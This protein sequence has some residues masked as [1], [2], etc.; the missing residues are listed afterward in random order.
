MNSGDTGPTDSSLSV[1]MPCYNEATTVAE[2]VAAVLAQPVVGEL[3]IVDDGSTDGTR[4]VLKEFDDPRVRVIEQPRNMGKG[5]ALRSGFAAATCP[6]VIVQDADLEYDPGEFTRL[7]APLV[8]G[9]A[10]V[11]YGSRFAGAGAHRVLMFWHS[12][13]NKFLTMASNMFTDLNLTDMETCYKAFR[14][15]VIQSIEIEED[16]FGFEPEVTAKIAAAGW[17]VFEIG[18][19]YN[20]RTYADGKKI[21]WRDGVRAVWCIIRYSPVGQRLTRRVER[22]PVPYEFADRE[23][24]S[25]LSVLEGATDYTDWLIE[26]FGPHLTGEIVE[27]GAG[28]GTITAH[29][30]NY[31]AVTAIEPSERAIESLQRRFAADSRVRVVHGDVSALPSA[32]C[33][34]VVL[35]NVLEHVPDDAAVLS[36]IHDA[37]RPDGRI[38]VFAPAF[39]ALYSEFD[40]QIGHYRRYQLNHLRSNLRSAGFDVVEARYVNSIGA[41]AWLIWAR[42]LGRTPTAAGPVTVYN[43]LFLP[44]LRR[45]ERSLR[46]PFGQSILVVGQRPKR[47]I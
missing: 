9:Q 28:S 45:I 18:V 19:S 20:G 46:V 4:G 47:K 25:T 11:V 15:E 5:A 35:S 10:D 41:L 23:L 21:G 24:L 37:L 22:T 32:S 40:R 8:D 34:T 6:F 26:M 44:L 14:R 17:R 16:R 29:L 38:V 3:V 31:G 39:D 27:L 1:I 33:D 7:I 43:Q 13:G 36:R 42:L 30:A 2:C 12:M